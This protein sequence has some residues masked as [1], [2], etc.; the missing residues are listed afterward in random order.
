[1]LSREQMLL[2]SETILEGKWV[3]EPDR[4]AVD[5]TVQ[6]IEHLVE[7]HLVK[8]AHDASGWNT[9]FR[10]PTDERLW[11]KIFPH[12]HLNGGGPPTL[13]LIST[14]AAAAKYL[15]ETKS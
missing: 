13:R 10:D 6:R 8:V 11:E 4:P 1:M 3:A 7:H 14:S 9:L 2:P 12:S 15:L 5:A